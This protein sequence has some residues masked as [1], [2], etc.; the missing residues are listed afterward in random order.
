MDDTLLK[1]DATPEQVRSVCKEAMKYQTASV[2]VNTSYVSFVAG[3]L[4]GSK[5]KTCCVIGFPLGAC[6]TETKVAET[7]DAIEKGAEEVDMVIHVGAAKAGNWDY[8][9]T[10]PR[11]GWAV[12]I[13][14][15]ARCVPMVWMNI[16]S[17]AVLR[18][19]KSSRN[20]MCWMRMAWQF[21]SRTAIRIMPRNG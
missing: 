15:G 11:Y 6:T 3:E 4:Q 20:Q 8:V 13:T 17:P 21:I 2:C 7:M 10:L 9:K 18:I 12:T 14:N 16:T 5:V 1:A 19:A